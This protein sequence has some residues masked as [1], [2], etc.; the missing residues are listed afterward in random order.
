MAKWL[1]PAFAVVTLVGLGCERN[2]GRDVW[3]DD[4][5]GLCWR[6]RPAADPMVTDDAEVYCSELGDGWRMPSLSEL[7]TLIRG[8][9]S[10][11]CGDGSACSSCLYLE[12]PGP[13]GCYWDRALG[14]NCEGYYWSTT[15]SSVNTV[16]VYSVYFARA[17]IADDHKFNTEQLVRCVKE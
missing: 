9:S 16:Y 12:G 3:C 15:A 11:D 13:G 5:S 4:A 2:D 1:I 10:G 8:C 17:E 6:D 7:R 14:S